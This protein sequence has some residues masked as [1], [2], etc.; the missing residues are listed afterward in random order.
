MV[1]ARGLACQDD[2]V[3]VGQVVD[4]VN[5]GCKPTTDVCESVG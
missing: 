5:P 1:P 3:P 4:G 2:L